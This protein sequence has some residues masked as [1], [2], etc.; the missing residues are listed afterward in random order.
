MFSIKPALPRRRTVSTVCLQVDSQSSRSDTG[1][2]WETNILCFGLCCGLKASV[3]YRRA[4]LLIRLTAPYLTQLL[5][6]YCR[7]AD[8]PSVVHVFRPWG[9]KTRPSRVESGEEKTVFIPANWCYCEGQLIKAAIYCVL[10]SLLL[11]Q[12]GGKPPVS[13]KN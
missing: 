13:R 9:V 8:G 11:Q 10:K 3:R 4:P 7:R 5:L 2:S 1:F 12:T 6:V